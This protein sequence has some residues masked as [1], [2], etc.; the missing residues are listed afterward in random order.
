M[1]NYEKQIISALKNGI[2]H[3]QEINNAC[4]ETINAG[5]MLNSAELDAYNKA[6]DAFNELLTICNDK[7]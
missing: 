7:L 4:S 2:S 6:L 5:I 3:M 1:T